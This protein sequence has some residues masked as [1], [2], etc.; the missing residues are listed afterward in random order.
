MSGSK[1]PLVVT[2]CDE[3]L[4][5]MLVHF[6]EWLD[7]AHEVDFHLEGHDFANAMR[8]RGSGQPIPHDE[9]WALLEGFFDTEMHRQTPISGAI[10]AIH[11]LAEEADV[12]V[13]TNIADHRREARTRQLADRG[14]DIRVFTNQGPKGPALKAILEEYSPSRAFFIDDLAQHHASAADM[15]PGI[16]RLHLVGEPTVAPHIPCAHEQGYAHARIDQ[17]DLALSWLRER[18]KEENS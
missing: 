9:M 18:L 14:L 2:D 8:R 4:L 17:W 3:V 16:V 13:L 5:H 1:R 15:V 7:E 11:T 10:E 12:V 6:R